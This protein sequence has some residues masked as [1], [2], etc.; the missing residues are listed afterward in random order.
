MGSRKMALTALAVFALL[1]QGCERD[2]DSGG[3]LPD[4]GA[5]PLAT[6]VVRAEVAADVGAPEDVPAQ[7]QV[8]DPATFVPICEDDYRVFCEAD[9]TAYASEECPVA[10]RED[11]T[12]GEGVCVDRICAPGEKR[13]EGTKTLLT[14]NDS[15][16]SW[17]SVTCPHLCEQTEQDG[18]VVSAECVG[19]P[20]CITGEKRCTGRYLEVCNQAG[21][22]EPVRPPCD[23]GCANAAC[24]EKVCEP[25]ELSCD[26]DADGW[27]RQCDPDQTGWIRLEPQCEGECEE[28]GGGQASCADRAC[29]PGEYRCNAVWLVQ[30]CRDDGEGFETQETCNHPCVMTGP[31]AVCGVCVGGDRRC[32]G[33]S[34]IPEECVPTTGYE[35]LP[36]CPPPPTHCVSGYCLDR[37]DFAGATDRAAE[38]MRLTQGMVDCWATNYGILVKKLCVY[39]STQDLSAAISETELVDF[40]CSETAPLSEADFAGGATDFES[41]EDLFTCSNIFGVNNVDFDADPQPGHDDRYCL[42]YDPALFDSVRIGECDT[43]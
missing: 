35:L 8:C 34:E 40:A 9:G 24:L 18:E 28:R 6:D 14:C 36:A 1:A 27:V 3:G 4:S 37:M 5:P 11:P 21:K 42:W 20:D 10:C 25:G 22:W 23:F 31:Q 15:G 29:T 38:L 33:G 12:S 2:D 43:F 16:K 17:W 19:Q 32:S 39:V 13:C 41:F 30:R 26:P 7:P